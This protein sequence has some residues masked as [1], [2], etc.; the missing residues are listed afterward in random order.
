MMRLLFHLPLHQTEGFLRSILEW[1]GVDLAVPDHTTLSRRHA[2]LKVALPVQP[3]HEPMH[4]VVDATGLKVSGEGE[5]KVRQ[6]GWR[7]RRTWRKWHIGSIVEAHLGRYKWQIGRTLRVRR[8]DY[9]QTE[10]RLG[11]AVL[12]HLLA[13]AKPVSYPVQKRA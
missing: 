8:T 6:H 3:R 5:W 2:D 4:R 11:C 10:A 1:M 9:Q 13:I 7:K 12:N